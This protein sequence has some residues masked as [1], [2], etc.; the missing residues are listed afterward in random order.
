MCYLKNQQVVTR[1]TQNMNLNSSLTAAR[2][3][4]KKSNLT[5]NPSKCNYLTIG[6]EVPLRLSFFPGGSGTTIPV[7]KLVKDLGV[8]ADNMFSP[9]AQCTEAANKAR[10]LIFKIRRSFHDLSK[11]LSSR[12][13]GP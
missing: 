1:R 2:H 8:Q 4:L 5:I 7:S 3:K 9:S 6:R 13:T 12:Y 10:Q 11:L